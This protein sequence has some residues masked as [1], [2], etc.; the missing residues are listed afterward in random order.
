MD[1][2]HLQG[3]ALAQN[4]RELE[5]VNQWLGGYKALSSALASL[6]QAGRLSTFGPVRLADL[7]SGAGDNLRHLAQWFRK[8]NIPAQLTGLDMNPAMLDFAR[9]RTQAFAEIDY[10][11]QNVLSEDFRPENY[12]LVTMSLFCHHFTDTEL[13]LL[14]RKLAQG[15]RKAV[16]INDLHRNPVAYYA[17]YTLSRLLPASYLFRH[18]A[19]LSVQRAFR[20]EELA[21]LLRTAGIHN[22]KIRWV[23]AFRFQVVFFG[24]QVPHSFET[25]GSKT[26]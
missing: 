16:I 19:P 9:Q 3:P 7:G 10:Q 4:L 6:H 8:K 15:V 14:F 23:W 24:S 11:L 21:N 13:V 22:F 25:Q 18:D 12:D 17:I 1:D 2:A 20:R 26:R 5:Q